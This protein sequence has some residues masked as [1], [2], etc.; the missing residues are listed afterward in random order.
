MKISRELALNILKY[1]LENKEF[2][3]PF[4]VVCKGLDG[5]D[6]FVEV[7]PKDD[8]E[9]LNEMQEYDNFELWENLQR[10]D[11]KTIRLMSKGFIEIITRRDVVD[12]ISTLAVEYRKRW[13]EDLCESVNIE[14]FGL[15]EYFGGKSEAFEES[16]EI[17]KKF[18]I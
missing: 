8:Y 16:V 12:N 17:I 7:V 13:N 2:S 3:F 4:I 5:S 1:L 15:N 6:E 18:S 11:E 10:L 9:M 14:E